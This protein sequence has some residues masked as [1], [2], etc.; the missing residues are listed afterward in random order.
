MTLP[1]LI[2]V[3]WATYFVFAMC[4]PHLHGLRQW[5]TISCSLVFISCA[6]IF[7]VSTHDGMC[8]FVQSNSLQSI[9][10]SHT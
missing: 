9:L 10:A 1:Y 5:S 8:T 6:F 7:G 2:I 3:F 4:V